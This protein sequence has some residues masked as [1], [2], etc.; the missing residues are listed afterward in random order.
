MIQ[1][2]AGLFDKAVSVDEGVKVCVCALKQHRIVSPTVAAA[3][4]I[5]EIETRDLRRGRLGRLFRSIRLDQDRD[6]VWRFDRRQFGKEIDA[7]NR[8]QRERWS[9]RAFYPG[10]VDRDAPVSAR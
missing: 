7:E 4:D 8:D 1:V 9:P 6:P 10:P 5:R 3:G 2:V